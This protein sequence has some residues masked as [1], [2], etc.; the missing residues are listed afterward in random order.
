MRLSR[1][2]PIS[3][4]F[5]LN[6]CLET[7]PPP[8]PVNL[9]LINARVVDGTG[10]VYDGAIIA[11][12]GERIESIVRA[13]GPFESAIQIDLQGKTV[14]PG[15]INTH[16]HIGTLGRFEDQE[17]LDQY[18]SN[19]LPADLEEYLAHGITS[20]K[21][22]GD[23][24]EAFIPV[25]ERI[26]R[27]DLRGPRVF[28][29]GPVLSAPGGHPGASL[30]PNNAW[31]RELASRELT[32]EEEARTEVR[33]LAEMGV[34]AIKFVYHGSSDDA[35]PYMLAPGLPIRKITSQVME[36][37]I[38]EAHQLGLPVTAHTAELEDAVAVLEAGCDGL[39]HGVTRSLIEGEALGAL[40]LEK[41]ALYGPTLSGYISR[42]PVMADTLLPNVKQLAEQ[43]V[44][45][46]LGTDGGPGRGGSGFDT[47]KE[48]ELLVQAGLTPQQAIQAG[49]RNAAQLLGKLDDLGTLEAGKLA[50]L[51]VVDGDPLADI[52]VIHNI[53][54][55]IKNGIIVVDNR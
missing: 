52:S 45:M 17:T 40:L 11:I 53:E 30:Y 42:N 1:L 24:P 16:I 23:I 44:R 26:K 13:P 10:E 18:L 21:S 25:R 41:G 46:V 22:T 6:A 54:L 37:I 32:T 47:L 5:L 27:G 36:A 31:L 34:D 38:A 2:L 33:Q 50:D 48:L 12:R 3:T 19:D 15:L 14:L 51:I 55:V 20:V 9:L 4:L 8:E 43:G 29:A 7:Q 39:E 49:T 35:K 28:L